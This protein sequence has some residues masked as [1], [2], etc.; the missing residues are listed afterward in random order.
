M[1][2]S[3]EQQLKFVEQLVKVESPVFHADG[4]ETAI[5]IWWTIS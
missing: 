5:E 4:R 2:L 3:Q 1:Q